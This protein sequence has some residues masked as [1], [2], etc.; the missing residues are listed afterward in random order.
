MFSSQSYMSVTII[1]LMMSTITNIK[2]H[3]FFQVT[4]VIKNFFP[5]RKANCQLMLT[6]TFKSHFAEDMKFCYWMAYQWYIHE[7]KNG[8]CFIH[9]GLGTC[10][11]LKCL[12]KYRWSSILYSKG[13]VLT[14][15]LTWVRHALLFWHKAESPEI[16]K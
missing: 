8:A 15:L 5:F 13:W 11:N 4:N 2:R 10:L 1:F 7:W 14:Q 3:S 16:E 9:I 6:F 12:V